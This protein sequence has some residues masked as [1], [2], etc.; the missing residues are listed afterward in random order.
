MATTIKVDGTVA[1]WTWQDDQLL[2]PAADVDY[3]VKATNAA[4]T[5]VPQSQAGKGVDT[6]GSVLKVDTVKA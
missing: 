4:A 3:F 5:Y 6:V 1:D 2:D